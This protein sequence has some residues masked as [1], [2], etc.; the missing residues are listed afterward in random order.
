MT[1]PVFVV[2]ADDEVALT[3][4]RR[5]ASLVA[6]MMT[7]QYPDGVQQED[8]DDT[9]ENFYFYKPDDWSPAGVFD[10]GIVRQDVVQDIPAKHSD[11]EFSVDT[12]AARAAGRV[13]FEREVSARGVGQW[14]HGADFRVGSRAVARMWGRD[15]PTFVSRVEP[16]G[17]GGV[18]VGLGG[19]LISDRDELRVRE[20]RIRADLAREA[21][22]RERDKQRLEAQAERDRQQTQQI[23]QTQTT[24]S[25]QQRQLRTH[26]AQV[27]SWSETMTANFDL[28]R[29]LF[30]ELRLQKQQWDGVALLFE[31]YHDNSG[32]LRDWVAESH[33]NIQSLIQQ[34]NQL[35]PPPQPPTIP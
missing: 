13:V 25:S 31:H 29:Q 26:S 33:S 16:D 24:L 34:L 11:F 30:E 2:V 1:V 10:F 4:P 15:V 18:G 28:M 6:G 23:K 5:Q 3:A 17:V 27:T 32:A 14:E 20:A 21:A 35:S 22:Q 9:R 8:P 19:K 12:A 7:T